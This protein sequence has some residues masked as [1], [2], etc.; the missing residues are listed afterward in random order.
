M[1]KAVESL[2]RTYTFSEGTADLPELCS[3]WFFAK[4]ALSQYRPAEPPDLQLRLD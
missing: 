3:G 1:K 4:P 2:A